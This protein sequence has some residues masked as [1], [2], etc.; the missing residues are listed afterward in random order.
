MTGRS[1][2]SAPYLSVRPCVPL[3][4]HDF[5]QNNSRKNQKVL[6]PSAEK[7]FLAKIDE[8]MCKVAVVDANSSEEGSLNISDGVEFFIFSLKMD[9]LPDRGR[10]KQVTFDERILKCITIVI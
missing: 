3:D 2:T 1:R 9:F 10:K 4:D 6:Y 7:L 5:L 8:S